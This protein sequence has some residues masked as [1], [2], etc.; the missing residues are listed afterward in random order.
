MYKSLNPSYNASD[1]CEGGLNIRLCVVLS[2]G[3]SSA[4]HYHSL[5]K[6]Q[7]SLDSHQAFYHES[8]A[9][10]IAQALPVLNKSNK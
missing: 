4:L 5:S 2:P 9:T 10:E 8:L 1:C 3:K 6:F 7:F